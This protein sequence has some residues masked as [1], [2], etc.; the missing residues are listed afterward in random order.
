MLLVL[1]EQALRRDQLEYF[2]IIVEIP[3]MRPAALAQ[4]LLGFRQGDVQAPLTRRRT[5]QQE[6]AGDGRLAG[7]G[8]TLEEIEAATLEASSGDVVE[9]GNACRGLV[10]SLGHIDSIMNRAGEGRGLSASIL[11]TVAAAAP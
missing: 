1:V 4:F 9:P 5:R 7:A 10:I 8:A 11:G 2:D 3:A 6:L